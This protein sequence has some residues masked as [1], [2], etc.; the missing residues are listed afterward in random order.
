MFSCS[1]ASLWSLFQFGFDFCRFSDLSVGWMVYSLQAHCILRRQSILH[2]PQVMRRLAGLSA[3]MITESSLTIMIIVMVVSKC[4]T[5]E[6]SHFKN[7]L[8]EYICIRR[9]GE[10]WTVD[11]L[12]EPSSLQ[13]R[14]FLINIITNSMDTSM[15][16]RGR[17]SPHPQP[18]CRPAGG[19][20]GGENSWQEEPGG[21]GGVLGLG[22]PF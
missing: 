22:D 4:A 13:P 9:V 8:V 1:F 5:L 15:N 21:D 12:S 11:F 17:R 20:R 18:S 16:T 2:G 7:A 10:F 19:R 14:P 6:V 3:R